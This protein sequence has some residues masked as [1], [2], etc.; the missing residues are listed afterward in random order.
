MAINPLQPTRNFDIPTFAPSAARADPS[1]F[2][3][4]ASI[5]DA[6]AE[7]NERNTLGEL[8]QSAT[9]Q[10]GN[11]DLNKAATAIALSGRDPTRYL[12][13]LGQQATLKRSEAGL[14]ETI[15]SNRETERQRQDALDRPDIHYDPGS[16]LR[17]GGVI[18]T[19]RR[20]G[21]V[22][23]FQ[24]LDRAVPAPAATPGP[25][26]SL[27]VPAGPVGPLAAAEPGPESGPPYRVAGPP[28]AAPQPAPAPAAT[29]APAPAAAAPAATAARDESFLKSLP[30]RAQTIIKGIADY[31]IDP[32][33]L[34]GKD[35]EEA[36]A[37]AKMYR[38]DYNTSEYQKRGAPP[39]AE[40]AARTGLAR[41]FIE[42]TPQIRQ[43][44]EAGE[45]N[46]IEG[47][48][49]AMVGQGGAGELRR[50]IDEGAEGLLRMLTG[51]GM[52]KDE[53]SDYTRRYKFS[54]IDTKDTQLRKLNELE[55]ALRYTATEMGKGR[56][57]DDLVKGYKSKFGE[58]VTPE[59]KPAE[60]PKVKNDAEANKLIGQARGALARDPGKRDEIY[61]RLRERGV[62]NPEVLL[63]Q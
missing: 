27:D 1:A 31:E 59:Q 53:A 19:P 37:A 4:I 35:R 25:Q 10:S 30:P 48:A 41:A 28:V 32:G 15:R 11:L 13:A 61:K 23:S 63:G 34:Q 7:R 49:Q 3:N 24:P 14:A 26:S 57:G 29:S 43:R 5:G 54:L 52:N 20:P 21:A 33:M 50:A 17:P 56:G 62:P 60:V 40:A 47:R 9:D 39:S 58:P 38:P 36:I 2:N 51:A 42:R 8:L 16:L 18:T 46:N 45:L 12:N 55:N 44:L 22:P 6:I